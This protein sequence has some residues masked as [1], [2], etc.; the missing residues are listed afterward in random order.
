M[1]TLTIIAAV[2]L[3]S[4]LAWRWLKKQPREEL[5][6]NIS[7]IVLVGI[8]AVLILLT[9]T[10]RAHWLFGLA[11]AAMP[12]AQRAMSLLRAW[13]LVQRLAGQGGKEAEGNGAG[14]STIETRFL[15][16]QMDTRTGLMSGRVLQGIFKGA[17]L[18]KMPFEHLTRLLRELRIENDI[19]S[20]RL[21]EA[22][23]G[24]RWPRQWQEYCDSRGRRQDS[25]SGRSELSIDDA[26]R[27]L[28][29]NPGASPEEIRAA[30]RR[31][32]QRLHP[33]RGG[34]DYLATRV[35]QAKDML[36]KHHK[37]A[38]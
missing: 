5:S 11:G 15:S 23:L 26:Y 9:L 12:F 37:K 8:G 31:L 10:G 35:N 34:S 4:F 32:M 7:K 22:F 20:L 38:S 16:V 6:R 30:H 3:L 14:T 19:D 25:G 24:S 13:R 17:S 28:G 29:L 2:G 36:I 33:D 1:R 21:L 27:L 18:H